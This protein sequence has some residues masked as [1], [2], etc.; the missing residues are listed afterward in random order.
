MNYKLELGCWASVFAVPNVLIDRHLKLCG[1]IELKLLLLMLRHS[2][3]AFSTEELAKE[4]GITASAAEDS[5][6]YWGQAGLLSE[7]QG[8]MVPAAA[9]APEKAAAVL[10]SPA[11]APVHSAEALPMKKKMLRPDS[12]YIAKRIQEAPD[13]QSLFQDS[14][15]MLGKTLS[16]ALSAVLLTAHDDYCLPAEVILML[17]SYVASTG[18]TTTA[19]IEALVKNWSEDGVNSI[20]DAEIKIKALDEKIRAWKKFLSA[21]GTPFRAPSKNEEELSYHW[22]YEMKFSS[23]MLSAA[24]ERC[25]DNTGKLSLKYIRTILENWYKLGIKTPES[26]EAY[27]ASYKKKKEEPSKPSFDIDDFDNFKLFKAADQS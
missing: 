3:R 25:V 9:A 13:I 4:L 17:V 24:Y 22:V 7:E 8:V 5:L 1:E 10:P 26:L 2:G 19:Y 11:V 15:A 20:A 14:E 16:P 6:L 18:K 12:L 27:E 21:T 23:A